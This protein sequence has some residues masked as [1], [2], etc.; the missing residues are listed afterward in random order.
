M[1]WQVS[2]SNQDSNPQDLEEVYQLILE[3]FQEQ[4]EENWEEKYGI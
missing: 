3:E 1:A 4:A 2:P